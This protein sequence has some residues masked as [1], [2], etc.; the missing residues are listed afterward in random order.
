MAIPTKNVLTEV[1]N[2]PGEEVDFSIGDAAFVMEALSDLYSNK[3]L[4][5]VR[6]YST[7]ARDSHIEAGKEDVPIEVSLPDIYNPYFVVQDFG[8]GMDER[9]L[10]DTYT[11]YGVS[12][13][14]ATNAVNGMM[15]FGSKSAISYTNQYTVEAVKDDIK[16]IAVINKRPDDSV[17]LKIVSKKPTDDI[18]G[19]RIIIPVHNHMEFARK[20]RD[21]YRFWVPGTVLVNGEQPEQA[22]GEKIDDNLYYSPQR[23]I[24]YVVMGNVGYRI[25]NPDAL[26]AN[27]R[28]KSISFVAYVPNGAVRFTP[29][30]EDLKYDDHTKK[31]LQSV[32]TDFENKMLIE[33]KHQIET[34]AD[35]ATAW[36]LWNNWGIKLGNNLFDGME[37]KGRKFIRN[38]PT[39]GGYRYQVPSLLGYNP[40]Q[41]THVINSWDI[42]S[43][44]ETLI[45]TEITTN[46]TADIKRKAREY[47]EHVG[48]KVKYV[49]FM[50]TAPKCEWIPAERMVTWEVLKASIPR[51]PKKPRSSVNQR[52]KGLFDYYDNALGQYVNE[53]EIPAGSKVFYIT[54]ADTKRYNRARILNAMDTDE[55]IVVVKLAMNRLTK[56]ARDYSG[57]TNFIDWAKSKV[58]I[59]TDTLLDD[60][61]KEAMLMDERMVEWLDKMEKYTIEDPE[62]NVKKELRSAETGSAYKNN[63][64]IAESLGM[65]YEIK[66]YRPS[67]TDN[68]LLIKYPLLTETS[69]RYTGSESTTELVIY[70]NA[71]YNYLKGTP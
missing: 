19:V 17:T 48:L 57:A 20:A 23:G 15:G 54:A 52:P 25:N 63:I 41:N 70:I 42:S 34:A 71:K 44:P 45:V 22:V 37:Y 28:M 39:P 14:R 68:S 5:L 29:S 47:F 36:Q 10:M 11:S 3:E 49:L 1:N 58:V 31:T 56:F 18:N 21:F 9:E 8:L 65:H 62:W 26:F 55:P 69:A 46:L 27:A 2:L 30:R 33:A 13:K 53:K 59:D 16:T 7:N 4:A 61:A 50:P 6:E 64:A 60:K 38:F 40:K 24:S 35:H 67:K 43:L 32:I 12:T 51:A 66:R